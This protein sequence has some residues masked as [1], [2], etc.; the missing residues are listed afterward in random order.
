M[1]STETGKGLPRLGFLG[2]GWIGLHRMECIA[3]SGAAEIA[4][5]CDSAALSITKVVERFPNVR[6]AGSLDELL[7]AGLDGIVIATPSALHTKQSI[8]ALHRGLAVFCQ[9]PLGRNAAE[10]ASIVHTARGAD[11]LLG[12]DLSYRFTDGMRQIHSA[13]AAGTIGEVYA[14]DLV[15]H[16]AYGPD[17]QWFFDSRLAGGGCVMDLGVHLIDLMLW[18]L[19]FPPVNRVAGNLFAS[20][21]PL[22]HNSSQVEDYAIATIEFSSGTVARVA[23]SWKLP[24]GCDAIISANFYGSRGGLSFYNV[25][26][27]FYDFVAER[28]S[29]TSR[30]TLSSPPDEWGGRAAVAW[31]T[32]LQQDP[33]FDCEVE[34]AI[35]VASVLDAI[36][37]RHK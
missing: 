20:G 14:C 13:I 17:K 8:R 32:Q 23:C 22:E 36:Y 33:G 3:K 19:D 4:C 16:N 29:G 26:G 21:K 18:T 6:I 37:G 11:R 12:I 28:F 2:V 9:K 10:V 30:T 31:T 24:V 35:E 15:F 7:E 25:N 1:T 34:H 5:V 27:S